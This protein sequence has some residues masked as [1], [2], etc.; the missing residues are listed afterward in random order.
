MPKT[1]KKWYQWF[2]CLALNIEKGKTGSFSK[3]QIAIIPSLRAFWKI[4]LCQ[5]SS[6]DKYCRNKQI[7]IVKTMSYI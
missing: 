5:I 2:P 4:D 3:K 7:N 1:L 6:L